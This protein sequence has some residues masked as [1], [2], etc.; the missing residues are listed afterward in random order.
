MQHTWGKGIGRVS[1]VSLLA[2]PWLEAWQK[3]DDQPEHEFGRIRPCPGVVDR[4]P[5]W[6]LPRRLG[7]LQS[8]VVVPIL[9]LDRLPIELMASWTGRQLPMPHR[10]IPLRRW[11]A[12]ASRWPQSSTL[13]ARDVERM[14]QRPSIESS[15]TLW[16]S[17]LRFDHDRVPRSCGTFLCPRIRSL[18]RH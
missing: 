13:M 8:V 12:V 18:P 5:Q 7:V 14:R 2:E 4:R 1:L 11:Q 16:P 9:L 6:T 17:R 3:R 15:R 10:Q